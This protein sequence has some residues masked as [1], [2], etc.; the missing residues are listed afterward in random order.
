MKINE[1]V[2]ENRERTD[3][4]APLVGAIAGGALSALEI[5]QQYSEYKDMVRKAKAMPEGPDRQ[6]ALDAAENYYDERESAAVVSLLGG[7]AA[8][9]TGVGLLSGAARGLGLLK[10]IGGKLLSKGKPDPEKIA[11]AGDP[12][13]KLKQ[14]TDFQKSLQKVVDKTSKTPAGPTSK[15]PPKPLSANPADRIGGAAKSK[16]PAPEPG[17]MADV[18]STAKTVGKAKLKGAVVGGVSAPGVISALQGSEKRLANQ[19]RRA[20]T[21]PRNVPTALPGLN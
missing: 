8:G 3:E 4:L 15:L 10:R 12:L 2:I 11:R 7:A 5:A 19:K 16:K 9:A 14:D 17:S 1:I 6:K 13:E 21:K 18:T 20:D